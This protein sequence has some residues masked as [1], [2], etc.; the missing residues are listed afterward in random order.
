MLYRRVSLTAI[1]MEQTLK[2]AQVVPQGG[3]LLASA[4]GES[5][6]LLQKIW[7]SRQSAVGDTVNRI[8]AMALAEFGHYYSE[9]VVSS[10]QHKRRCHMLLAEGARG[11]AV[12][13]PKLVRAFAG[14]EF[15]LTR[16]CP[17]LPVLSVLLAELTR[18]AAAYC[19]D[20]TISTTAYGYDFHWYLKLPRW[21]SD[22]APV[23]VEMCSSIISLE[24]LQRPLLQP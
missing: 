21:S 3:V 18:L 8:P 7:M 16:C 4:S 14:H 6:E 23:Y 19:Q 24:F 13:D 12:Y 20:W 9:Y 17:S 10:G 11:D 22:K 5:H 1:D 2:L 15:L